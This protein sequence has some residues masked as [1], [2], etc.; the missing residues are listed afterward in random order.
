[1]QRVMQFMCIDRTFDLKEENYVFFIL[2]FFK[3]FP[4][5]ESFVYLFVTEIIDFS[6]TSLKIGLLCKTGYWTQIVA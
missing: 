5:T 3:C 4:Y 6:F 2:S 1:M